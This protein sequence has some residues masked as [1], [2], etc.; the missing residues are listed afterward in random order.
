MGMGNIKINIFLDERLLGRIEELA[1]DME[2][3]TDRLFEMAAEEF[4][5]RHG[6][7]R[8]LEFKSMTYD[9][10]PA[11]EEEEA[12]MRTHSAASKLSSGEW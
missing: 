1:R 9:D 8:Q 3:T 2:I 11:I 4:V 7:E 10:L 12:E 5:K 6:A